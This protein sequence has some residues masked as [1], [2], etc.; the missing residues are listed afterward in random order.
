MYVYICV[1]CRPR[2]GEYAVHSIYLMKSDYKGLKRIY[3]YN[4]TCIQAHISIYI[5]GLY[6]FMLYNYMHLC[7]EEFS[8]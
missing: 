1:C 6:M 8:R 4:C 7:C 2:L 5:L 3:M